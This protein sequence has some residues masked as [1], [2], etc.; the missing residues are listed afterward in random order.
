MGDKQRKLKDKASRAYSDGDLKDA[1]KLY[2]RVVFEDPTELQ[3][4]L[5]LGDI[6]RKMGNFSAAVHEYEPVARAYAE[7]GLLLKA[8]AVCKM[9][10]GVD[11]DHTNTQAMLADLY[12]KRRGTPAPQAAATEGPP[13]TLEAM[14]ISA[15]SHGN[16]PGAEYG[17]IDL[18]SSGVKLEAPNAP[19]DAPS[20]WPQSNAIADTPAWPSS[21]SSTPEA[22]TS[23]PAWPTSSSSTPEAKPGGA[24]PAAA[25][26]TSGAP[27]AAAW[28]T[29]NAVVGEDSEL[30][31]VV[32]E[33]V[34]DAPPR[35]IVGERI[36]DSVLDITVDAAALDT[37][38]VEVDE[39]ADTSSEIASLLSQLSED[40]HTADGDEPLEVA[41]DAE[42]HRDH[43]AP[44]NVS[45][46]ELEIEDDDGEGFAIGM[47]P[48]D[49]SA[50]VPEGTWDGVI[51]I[52][53]V[54]A[55]PAQ[56]E[57]VAVDE[58]EIAEDA[59]VIELTEP[60]E[61]SVEGSI[62]DVARPQIPLFS[63]L[64]KNAFIELLVQMD[65]REMEPGE[66]VIREGESGDS[67]F[68][69]ASGRVRVTRRGPD[70]KDVDLAILTDGAFFGEMA[71]LQD[72]ARTASV[73][74][75]EEAQIFEINKEVLDHVVRE[76]PSV[77]AVLRNFYRQRLLSTAMAT[78]PLFAPFSS[79]ERRA[80]MEMFKSKNFVE[81]EVLLEEGKKGT[82]LF[83][84]LYG[85]LEVAKDQPGGDKLVLASLGPG[86]MFG[87]MSLLTNQP[88]VASVTAMSDCFVLRLSKKKFDELIMTHPQI[89]E[90][91]AL[92]SDERASLNDALQGQAAAFN[93]GAVLV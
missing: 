29:S 54:D 17:M 60:V 33:A 5:K 41:A 88:T 19:T 69:V 6:H 74:V 93:A 45:D 52:E 2:E 26:P 50:P 90:L 40:S 48:T 22:S 63:D 57:V 4:R 56:A 55:A 25:W 89:L 53:D 15:P 23:A 42:A 36:E 58:A 66:Y 86:D 30:D 64:P 9:I 73:I 24:P 44:G 70:G 12:A 47:E 81:G 87:E 1:L 28:P 32:G 67:F 76:Y 7:D 59:P 37:P 27:P 72:G 49:P 11:P 3:C 77:A 82:G 51:R 92:V 78:H 34:E 85:A 79:D 83:I 20:S 46:E 8:I 31:I 38:E 18:G 68:V 39:E 10:L 13:V 65:M 84:L 71:L 80:L 14:G 61:R 21:S 43:A 91:V 75:E 62:G 16:F 35:V